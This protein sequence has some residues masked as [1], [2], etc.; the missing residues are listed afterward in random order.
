[1]KVLVVSKSTDDGGYKI[2]A[3]YRKSPY[4]NLPMPFNGLV[5]RAE[6]MELLE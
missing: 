1:M 3:V 2:L 6:E 5:Y 4:R